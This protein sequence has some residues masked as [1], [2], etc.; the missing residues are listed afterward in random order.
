MTAQVTIIAPESFFLAT[1]EH[2]LLDE[3]LAFWNDS[4]K[5]PD[6]KVDHVKSVFKRVFGLPEETV[7]AGS[8]LPD[9]VVLQSSDDTQTFHVIVQAENPGEGWEAMELKSEGQI[10]W[11]KT[12]PFRLV[13]FF[14]ADSAAGM[15]LVKK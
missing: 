7:L 13:L 2:E 5:F 15:T 11:A 10:S 9:A 14:L 3:A 1:E 6:A 8:T 12:T 4:S